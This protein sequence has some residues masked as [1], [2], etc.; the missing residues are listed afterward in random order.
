MIITTLFEEHFGEECAACTALSGTG[1]SARRYFRLIGKSGRSAIGVVGTGMD[2]NWAF[3]EMSRCFR[4]QSLPVPE[5]YA[6]SEDGLEYIQEDL[7]DNIL[8]DRIEKIKKDVY[9]S[10]SSDA[11]GATLPAAK[12]QKRLA[13]TLLADGLLQKTVRRLADLQFRGGAALDFDVCHPVKE[14]GGM[15]I[16][17]DLNYFKYCFLK[18]TGLP[19]DELK[20]QND[21]E[22]L[23]SRLLGCRLT[24]FLM[25]DCQARN[26]MIKDNEAYFIDF[27]GGHRG[28]VYY[29]LASFLW[30]ARAEYPSA[31]RAALLEEY[32]DE[33]GKYAEIDREAFFGK[34][35]YF[36]LF[37]TL[38]V[39]GCYGF[40]GLYE[41]KS[42]FA[43][44]LPYAMANIRELL[45]D[46]G[47]GLP[48]SD[49]LHDSDG[50]ATGNSD[51][52]ALQ[53][54]GNS[55]LRNC[56]P[57]L[58]ELLH[59][60]AEDKRYAAF[61]ANRGR[62]TVEV[63]SFS[64]RKGIPHDYSNNGG[65]YVFDCRYI[66][67]PGRYEPYKAFTGMDAC[68][69]KFLEDDGEV[70]DFLQNVYGLVDRHVETYRRRGFSHLRVDFGCTGG[71]HR[72]VYCA[73]H[74]ATHIAGKFPD[75]AVRLIHREQN[76]EKH[77]NLSSRLS[78]L[79]CHLD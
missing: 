61:P 75:V 56:F 64:Y 66:H 67:N 43:G 63:S 58:C 28:P 77:Y 14:F 78:T 37:R 76:V 11:E 24:G 47:S 15:Q 74:L 26:V 32:L 6:I 9:A 23:K 35:R 33:A 17:F 70:T 34:L 3:V 65:G 53:S 13:Q 18:A 40:R 27:Q 22:A 8:F 62:L 68:V 79:S 31:L 42:F 51:S 54:S 21:F 50:S 30:Q 1:A 52:T 69:Q 10:L 4:S 25:R 19:F 36:V 38:Q 48:G 59:R 2:E 7:G 45:A 39:L 16:D 55:A 49:A 5:V 72:S 73:E 71:Q 29:D 44:S 57:Y 46:E 60:L 12:L 20:L 41:K